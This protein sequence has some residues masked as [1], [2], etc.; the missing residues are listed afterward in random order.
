MKTITLSEQH[1]TF[2]EHY[3]TSYAKDFRSMHLFLAALIFPNEAVT[4]VLEIWL[5]ILEFFVLVKWDI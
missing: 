2:K 5:G 1:A 3:N 4:I